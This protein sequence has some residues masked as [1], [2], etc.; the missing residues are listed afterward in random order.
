MF[1]VLYPSLGLWLV[2]LY[3][4][5]W[6]LHF[7]TNAC[8]AFV[9]IRHL[10]PPTTALAAFRWRWSRLPIFLHSFLVASPAES[11]LMACRSRYVQIARGGDRTQ[12]APSTLYLRDF[13]RSPLLQ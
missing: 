6:L 4:P 11:V 1:C 5:R 3:D 13:I 2:V 12:C 7:F 10:D 8:P 9:C